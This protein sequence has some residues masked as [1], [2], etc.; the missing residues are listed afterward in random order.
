MPAR[1]IGMSAD[2]NMSCASEWRQGLLPER[3]PA[4]EHQLRQKI[5]KMMRQR[6]HILK[7]IKG[8][9]SLMK[10]DE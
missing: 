3:Q 5:A 4:D 6:G 7:L 1:P 8:V 2:A 10:G 9:E